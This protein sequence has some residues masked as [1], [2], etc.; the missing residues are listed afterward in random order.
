MTLQ[1]AAGIH[2]T[3]SAIPTAGNIF[4]TA[5]ETPEQAEPPIFKENVLIF[6]FFTCVFQPDFRQQS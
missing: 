6:H 4:A 2:Q 1:T 3:G 5:N